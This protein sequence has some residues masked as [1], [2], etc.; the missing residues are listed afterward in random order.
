ME[1]TYTINPL[2]E[3]EMGLITLA[4]AA[5]KRLAADKA[6]DA[7]FDHDPQLATFY[8]EMSEDAAIL[9]NKIYKTRELHIKVE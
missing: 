1:I 6:T 2:S 9:Y 5:L 7:K 4:L 8:S 3:E